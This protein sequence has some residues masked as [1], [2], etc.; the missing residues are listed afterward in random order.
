MAVDLCALGV[1][2][3][4]LKGAGESV[5][6]EVLE[7]KEPPSATFAERTGAGGG[8]VLTVYL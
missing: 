8:S 5:Q 7:K 2:E 4:D 6:R 1:P 3:L